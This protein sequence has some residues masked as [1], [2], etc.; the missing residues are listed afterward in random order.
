MN[1]KQL[2]ITSILCA[3]VLILGIVAYYRQS[4]S[5]ETSLDVKD[6]EIIKNF[7]VNKVNKIKIKNA[8]AFLNV[9]KKD[10]IWRVNEKSGYPADFQAVSDM[11]NTIAEMKTV[12]KID[13]GKEQLARFELLEPGKGAASG[14]IV[15][16]YDKDNVKM[17]AL[18]LGKQH[19][20][21][22]Q[23]NPYF[24][25]SYPDGRYLMLLD[26][27]NKVILIA[28]P[29]DML[30]PSIQAW[31]SKDFIRIEGIASV[32]MTSSQ[33]QNN[34]KISRKAASDRFTLEGIKKNDT[35]DE[36]SIYNISELLTKLSFA[37]VLPLSKIAETGLE[38]PDDVLTVDTFDG[39]RYILKTASRGGRYFLKI[40][41]ASL[42][43]PP[44][45]GDKNAEALKAGQEK[46]R[47]LNDKLLKE[48]I[49]TEW[50][51]EIPEK[52]ATELLK[53]FSDL[54]MKKTEAAPPVQ[55]FK[56]AVHKK[57]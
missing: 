8:S 18:L 27:K 56:K 15:E 28:D 26:G 42:D 48:K 24:D 52:T 23:D 6:R 38:K 4:S 14:T 41:M 57:K 49:F 50:I 16:L 39:L 33:K 34:W 44:L 22:G 20:A 5:W 1:R 21:Q 11:L 29:L 53:P 43:I 9:L 47:K 40:D 25:S 35:P 2:L 3:V 7:D 17:F 13:V 51:Y 46:A 12:R 10:S 31:L 37:D 30:Q 45:A 19:K 54:I 32:S 55:P 36:R